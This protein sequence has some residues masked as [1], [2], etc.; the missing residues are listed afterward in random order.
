[1]YTVLQN[2]SVICLN[3]L[4]GKREACSLLAAGLLLPWVCCTYKKHLISSL[5]RV[6]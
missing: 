3:V 1:M 4:P 2:E 5:S 6:N